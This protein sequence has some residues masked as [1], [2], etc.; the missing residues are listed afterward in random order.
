MCSIT[1]LEPGHNPSI[2]TFHLAWRS[3]KLKHFAFGTSV[4]ESHGIGNAISHCPE[5]ANWTS[6]NMHVFHLFVINASTFMAQRAIVHGFDSSSIS[7][8][9]SAR[10]RAISFSS[11][12][13]SSFE[14]WCLHWGQGGR[15]I[16]RPNQPNRFLHFGQVA[17]LD[18]FIAPPV[19]C[20]HAP[21]SLGEDT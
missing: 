10:A 1:L 20:R 19:I 12:S 21:Q 3:R 5:A 14:I 13:R 17:S 15:S 4:P 8:I 9:A 7:A 18:P 6:E 11:C 16:A 2:A